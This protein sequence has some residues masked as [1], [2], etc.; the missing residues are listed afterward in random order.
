MYRALIAVLCLLPTLAVSAQTTSE[1]NAIL[2]C[3][4]VPRALEETRHL[5]EDLIS[6]HSGVGAGSAVAGDADEKKLAD[7]V[8]QRFKTLPHY[9]SGVLSCTP[10]QLWRRRVDRRRQADRCHQ[11]AWVRRDMGNARRCS[12]HPGKRWR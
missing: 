8:E 11:P 5:S 10:V 12:L 2:Q 7:Y 3:I 1:E 6:N 9:T 4:S